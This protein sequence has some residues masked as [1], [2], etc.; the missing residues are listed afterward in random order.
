MVSRATLSADRKSDTSAVLSL[1][2]LSDRP[3][4]ESR[5]SQLFNYR[6]I[7]ELYEREHAVAVKHARALKRAQE[8]GS[9]EMP[10]MTPTAEELKEKDEVIKS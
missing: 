1:A 7:V 3:A 2:P 6:R 9:S 5:R 10:D 8:S 4:F